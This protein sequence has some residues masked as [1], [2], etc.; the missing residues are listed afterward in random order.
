MSNS[1]NY[2][3]LWLYLGY[4]MVAIVIYMSL[5]PNPPDTRAVFM[6]DKLLHVLTYIFFMIWFCQLYDSASY[7]YIGLYLFSL[8]VM[9]E[10]AQ[11]GVGYRFF[12]LADLVAN[13]SGILIGW[14]LAKIWFANLFKSIE[15]IILKK[16]V[17][18]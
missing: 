3:K 9:I 5:H 7:K 16:A 12:E 15:D 8:G 17:D 11:W 2:R 10:I 6:G 13:F 14:I 4:M 1:L 18:P